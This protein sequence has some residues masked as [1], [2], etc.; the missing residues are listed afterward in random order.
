L[1]TKKQRPDGLN[2]N[3]Q[4]A[5]ILEDIGEALGNAQMIYE[6]ISGID[7]IVVTPEVLSTVRPKLQQ[8]LGELQALN[9]LLTEIRL[10]IREDSEE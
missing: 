7:T 3:D 10:S 8:A 5:C 1:A 6:H 4:A 2:V 9:E